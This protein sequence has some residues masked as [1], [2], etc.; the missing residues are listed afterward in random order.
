MAVGKGTR[1]GVALDWGGPAANVEDTAFGEEDDRANQGE[2]N[3]NNR[4]SRQKR[5]GGRKILH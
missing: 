1:V 3:Q 2:K 5:I 4:Q